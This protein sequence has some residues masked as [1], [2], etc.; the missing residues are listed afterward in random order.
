VE[1]KVTI[2]EPANAESGLGLCGCRGEP[3]APNLAYCAPC[4]RPVRSD[5]R[6]DGPASRFS[7]PVCY[8]D[9]I[10]VTFVIIDEQPRE[11]WFRERIEGLILPIGWE[12]TGLGS[13]RLI[14]R[15]TQQ[16]LSDYL[17]TRAAD[18]RVAIAI[19]MLQGAFPLFQRIQRA[20]YC[21]GD[22]RLEMLLH[23]QNATELQMLQTGPLRRIN[24]AAGELRITRGLAAPEIRIDHQSGA[25][26]D[27]FVLG[28]LFVALITGRE[29][30]SDFDEL[31][32]VAHQ[33]LHFT[34]TLDPSFHPWLA[35]SLSQD[36]A[37]RYP[38]IAAQALAFRRALEQSARRKTPCEGPLKVNI[39]MKSERGLGKVESSDDGQ[40][41]SE[42]NQDRCDRT[43][44]GEG[45][46]LRVL[47][48]VIDGVS[49]ARFGSGGQAADV[50]RN[51]L[52]AAWNRNPFSAGEELAEALQRANLKIAEA[53]IREMTA[54]GARMGA[55]DSAG[56]FMA[57]SVAVVA[58][59]G[60]T[61][62]LANLGD[63]RIYL[64][65]AEGGIWL[66]TAD[67]H[68]LAS[69]LTAGMV[70]R[71]ASSREGAE[72]LDRYLGATRRGDVDGDGCHG[73]EPAAIDVPVRR[74]F[75][76]PKD[77]L[78][79]CSDGLM[80]FIAGGGSRGRWA[81]ERRV[82]EVLAQ[83]PNKPVRW[84]VDYLVTAANSNG[85]GD[86][87]TLLMVDLV[88]TANE[89]GSPVATLSKNTMPDYQTRR[90]QGGRPKNK[91]RKHYERR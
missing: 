67:H 62:Y 90:G 43:Q 70:W 89:S 81:A 45:E 54:K 36:P 15:R 5:L 47:A 41:E 48:F 73:W 32:Y 76:R 8:E 37:G 10:P 59:V 61:A 85:G 84:L 80:H 77:R 53:A 21:V 74:L 49:N 66:L 63:T 71:E 60:A 9:I 82:A 6:L 31:D 34:P 40:P 20:Q 35:Q 65:S 7:Q 24:S 87:I 91:P 4:G 13:W 83:N 75:L 23:W 42:I 86:N 39:Q 50:A 14:F 57:A 58:I 64:W 25:S 55:D 18:D 26:S 16:L 12:E 38:D 22:L 69:D 79:I 51:E 28:S 78:L 3:V 44:S 52:L 68:A 1:N 46:S 27:V 72:A 17:A 11:D 29:R 56:G 2:I 19:D 33:L 88:E 30:F